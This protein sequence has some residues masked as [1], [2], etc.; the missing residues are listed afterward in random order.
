MLLIPVLPVLRISLGN[1]REIDA[2]CGFEM[3]RLELA[4]STAQ[5]FQATPILEGT[6]FESFRPHVPANVKDVHGGGHSDHLTDSL[7][8]T[9]ILDVV[10]KYLCILLI[11]VGE[12]VLNRDGSGL[13]LSNVNARF[14]TCCCILNAGLNPRLSTFQARQQAEAARGKES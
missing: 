5:L 7:V 3:E 6:I 12:R 2:I 1:L 13:V 4:R 11:F 9:G 14:E 8:F 10:L